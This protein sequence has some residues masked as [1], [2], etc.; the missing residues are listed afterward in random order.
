MTDP[1]PDP[2]RDHDPALPPP[3][4]SE[5]V[6][7]SAEQVAADLRDVAP[8]PD[9]EGEPPERRH[10]S[11]IGGAFYLGILAATAVGLGIVVSGSW[12]LGVRWVAGALIVAAV[13]RLVLPRRDA[14]MLAVR[15]R[16]VDCVLLGTV[17]GVLVF[18][19][20]TIPNQP[21]L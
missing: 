12:R 5:V 8:G 16:L 9:P 20:Q 13:L 4:P 2:D 19:A 3:E 11:T 6:V 14:G 15:H 10:P 7:P 1:D 18:L 17:G 21:G